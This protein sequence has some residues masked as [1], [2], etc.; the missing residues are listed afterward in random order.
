M[1]FFFREEGG[2]FFG[3]EEEVDDFAVEGFGNG[4]EGVDCGVA[5]Y[6]GGDC[7]FFDVETLREG[8]FC[9]VALLEGGGDVELVILFHVLMLF[10]VFL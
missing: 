2:G 1:V 9:D 7:W 6:E 3:G 4:I 8:A 10:F 5:I